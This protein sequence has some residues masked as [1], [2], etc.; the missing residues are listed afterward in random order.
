VLAVEH[1]DERVVALLEPGSDRGLDVLAQAKVRIDCVADL[2]FA[3]VVRGRERRR[4]AACLEE[5]DEA[6]CVTG[7]GKLDVDGLTH[8]TPPLSQPWH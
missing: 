5:L 6:G 3:V 2:E 1:R 7:T 4:E 8:G